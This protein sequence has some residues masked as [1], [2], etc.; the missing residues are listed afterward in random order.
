MILSELADMSAGM[1]TYVHTGRDAQG[2]E[3]AMYRYESRK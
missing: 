1:S 2:R 3:G